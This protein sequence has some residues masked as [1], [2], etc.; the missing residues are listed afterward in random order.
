MEW[1]EIIVKIYWFY[2]IFYIGWVMEVFFGFIQL[3]ICFGVVCFFEKCIVIILEIYVLFC[4]GVDG[5]YMVVQGV[6]YFRYELYWVFIQQLF[7]FF[8]GI[9]CRCI[10]YVFNIV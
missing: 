3:D 2:D 6:L 7:G 8:K 1:A 9:V 5:F 10:V 4:Y